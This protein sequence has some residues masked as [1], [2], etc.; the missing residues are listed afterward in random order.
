MQT[1][2]KF[3]HF[4]F[5]ELMCYVIF[6]KTDVF[7]TSAKLICASPNSVDRV[8]FCNSGN[9]VLVENPLLSEVVSFKMKHMFEVDLDVP[10][11]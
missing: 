1:V 4:E 6:V 2:H 11:R 8:R 5:L 7:S 3:H 9:K 10:H